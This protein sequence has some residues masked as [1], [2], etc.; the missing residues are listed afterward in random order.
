MK[1]SGL[2]LAFGIAFL[3]ISAISINMQVSNTV[4]LT[5]K[6]FK[7]TV[8]STAEGYIK[9]TENSTNVTSYLIIS[10]DGINQT[11]K[12]PYFISLTRGQWI[13]KIYKQSYPKKVIKVINVTEELPCGNVT[14]QIIQ[15]FTV[16]VNTTNISYPVYLQIVISKMQITPYTML[17]RSLGIALFLI[18]LAVLVIERLHS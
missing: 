5:D 10:H 17:V 3:S 4:T 16:Y 1:L 12:A 14:R 15:N 6:P 7:L 9:I 11:I 8:P 13:V 2:F 18:G